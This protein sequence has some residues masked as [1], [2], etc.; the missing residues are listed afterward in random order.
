MHDLCRACVCA[1]AQQGSVHFSGG[2]GGG[3]WAAP[4]AKR[5]SGPLAAR[6]DGVWA[7]SVCARAGC[8]KV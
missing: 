5:K 7:A 4:E 3:N 1:H 6:R 2:G 8:R